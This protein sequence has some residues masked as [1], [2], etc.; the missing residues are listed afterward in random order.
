MTSMKASKRFVAS[1]Y[2]TGFLVCETWY[3]TAEGRYVCLCATE[4]GPAGP[5]LFLLNLEFP[6]S[7]LTLKFENLGDFEETHTNW[8][9]S[10]S[11][12][13]QLQH[14]LERKCNTQVR[15]LVRS[16]RYTHY[17]IL[18]FFFVFCDVT[19]VSSTQGSSIIARNLSQSRPCN[20]KFVF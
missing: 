20:C 6:A 19:D 9:D 11:C 18:F 2:L 3:Y 5:G 4:D 12:R 14:K 10:W 8:L 17:V 16:L 1:T 13:I 7:D 15:G